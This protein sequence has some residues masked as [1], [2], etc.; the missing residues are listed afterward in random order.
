[1]TKNK[2]IDIQILDYA[3]CFDSLSLEECTN[4]LFEYG[5]KN[6]HLNII[7]EANEQNMV[8]IKTPFGITPR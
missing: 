1:M 2:S 6:D 3:Q 4:D 7:Y 8:S 5:I